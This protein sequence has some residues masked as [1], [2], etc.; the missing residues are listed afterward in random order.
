MS[1]GFGVGD[2]LAVGA[3]VRNVSAAYANAPTEFQ[4]FSHEMMSLHAIV[5]KVEEQLGISAFDDIGGAGAGLSNRSGPQP[6]TSPEGME[7]LSMRDRDE[8]KIL[9]DGLRTIM[10]ELDDV[11]NKYR[12]LPLSHNPIDRFRWVQEDLGGLRDKL[13][14]NITL[15][16]A[17]N[18][19][20]TKC[21]LPPS[22]CIGSKHTKIFLHC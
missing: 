3:L 8:L 14:L 15:L 11:L 19:S 18:V 7:I 10:N 22:S 2:I 1:F 4:K 5:R 16:T 13:R 21:V 9:Y 20:L 17:F 6:A 12:S